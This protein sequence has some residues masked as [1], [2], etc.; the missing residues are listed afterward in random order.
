MSGMHSVG[1]A[2]VMMISRKM[3]VVV[4]AAA[5]IQAATCFS[6]TLLLDL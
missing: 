1:S 3:K 5:F 4:V 2:W 6:E